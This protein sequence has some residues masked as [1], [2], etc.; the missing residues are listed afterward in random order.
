MN[1]LYIAFCGEGT[2]DE[3]LFR[4]LTERLVQNIVLGHDLTTE[5]SW[6]PIKKSPGS[7]EEALLRAASD[8]K[9]QHV[10]IFHRDADCGSRDECLQHHFDS[11]LKKIQE[12]DTDERIKH[13]VPAIPI[14]ESEAWMLCDKTLL[15]DLLETNLNNE[16]L[17]LTYQIQRI[18]GI[19][20]PKAIIN[21]AIHNHKKE[22]SPRKRKLAV[23]LS[24]LYERFGTDIQLEKL[25]RLPSFATYQR[26][27]R[28]ALEAIFDVAE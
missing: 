17:G 21:R 9:E 23:K 22:L 14:Q 4:N 11:G 3:R 28:H 1:K 27:L 10:L 8:A 18:E 26:D 2:A 16:Q 19:R 20:D 24:E 6:L 5:L 7:S 13:I 25:L 12:M 15:K